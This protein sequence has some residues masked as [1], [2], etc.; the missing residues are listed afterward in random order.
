MTARR[1]PASPSSRSTAG[2]ATRWPSAETSGIVGPNLDTTFGIVRAQ[3]FD[4]STIRDVVRGQIAYPET[5]T[6]TGGPGMPAN[7]VTGQDADDVA[8]FVAQ[9]AQLPAQDAADIG[10][11]VGT[12]PDACG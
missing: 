2:S 7:I 12:L 4:E 9:C 11:D 1:T 5:E 8:D 3:G 10:V 6:A